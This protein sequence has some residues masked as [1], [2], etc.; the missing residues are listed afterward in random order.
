M[1]IYNICS[2][3]VVS[4]V[5]TGRTLVLPPLM[6]FYLLNRNPHGDNKSALDRYFDMSKIKDL[7]DVMP[8]QEFLEN[9]ANKG[10]TKELPPGLLYIHILRLTS[11]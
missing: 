10:L 9:V 1:I 11:I 5:V 7:L 2:K 4:L 6:S 3:N 8:M